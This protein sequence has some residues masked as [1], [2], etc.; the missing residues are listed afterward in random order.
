MTIREEDARLD[1]LNRIERLLNA[2]E[3]V[4]AQ[5][6]NAPVVTYEKMSIEGQPR[7]E[8]INILIQQSLVDLGMKKTEEQNNEDNVR[9]L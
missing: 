8:L 9:E 6:A 1:A 5:A 3:I 7:V 2:K 4:T